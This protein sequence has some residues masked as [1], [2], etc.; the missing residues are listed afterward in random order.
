MTEQE[1]RIEEMAKDLQEVNS[2]RMNTYAG[3]TWV[4]HDYTKTAEALIDRDYRKA[5]EVRKEFIDELLQY[6]QSVDVEYDGLHEGVEV[7]D[8]KF[9]AEKYGIIL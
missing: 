1:K 8:I 5:D 6:K 4:T 2:F 3:E 9:V 7:A